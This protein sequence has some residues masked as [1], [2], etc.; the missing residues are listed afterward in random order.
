MPRSRKLIWTIPARN[1]LV[2][3]REFIEPQN[4]EAARRAAENLKKAVSL[5]LE[6]PQIGKPME[7]REDRE[8]IIPFGKRGY[9]LRYR[10]AGEDIIILRVWHGLEE[11]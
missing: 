8:L 2:R 5:L 6:N 4:F 1:D 3:L 11:K 9:V 7:R 10:V